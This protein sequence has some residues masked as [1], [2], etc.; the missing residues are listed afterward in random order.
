MPKTTVMLLKKGFRKS[1]KTESDVYCNIV[2]IV[3]INSLNENCVLWQ[4]DDKTF[5]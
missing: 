3:N 1:K 5:P 4:R 2:N